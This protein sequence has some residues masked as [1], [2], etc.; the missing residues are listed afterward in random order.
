MVRLVAL[1]ALAASGLCQKPYDGIL[2]ISSPSSTPSLPSSYGQGAG[3]DTATPSLPPSDG[4]GTKY[5]TEPCHEGIFHYQGCAEVDLS[6]FTDPIV[7]SDGLLTHDACQLAC[8]GQAYAAL[9]AEY[10]PS[11]SAAHWLTLEFLSLRQ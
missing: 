10:V 11:P 3:D 5:D 1:L 2:S 4:Q 9:F 8:E 6:H 7:F